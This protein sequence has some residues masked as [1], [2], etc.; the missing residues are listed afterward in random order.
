[1][2]ESYSRG[3]EFKVRS[4]VFDFSLLLCYSVLFDLII[5]IMYISFR[6]TTQDVKHNVTVDLEHVPNEHREMYTLKQQ[7]QKHTHFTSS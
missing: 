2:C 5:K 7:L 3:E 4:F 6:Q 1:M